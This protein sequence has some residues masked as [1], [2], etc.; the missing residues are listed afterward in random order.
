[1]CIIENNVIL[2]VMPTLTW[3]TLTNSSGQFSSS[4][5]AANKMLQTHTDTRGLPL[6]LKFKETSLFRAL[7][8]DCKIK[9]SWFIAKYVNVKYVNVIWG[10]S[11]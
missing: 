4:M 3:F 6:D 10:M 11:K 2:C 7:H 1:M 5:K 8:N 9:V